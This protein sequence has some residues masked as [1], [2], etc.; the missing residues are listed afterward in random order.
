MITKNNVIEISY[1]I[2]KFCSI[3][4]AEIEKRHLL[5]TKEKQRNPD[6]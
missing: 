2:D 5:S 3:F 6:G 1:A 4:N